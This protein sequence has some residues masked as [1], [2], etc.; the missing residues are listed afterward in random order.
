MG[1][2]SPK[3]QRSPEKSL[4]REVVVCRS[5]GRSPKNRCATVAEPGVKK[6]PF[7]SPI[8]KLHQHRTVARD[9]LPVMAL[10][11]PQI[12]RMLG[13]GLPNGSNKNEET[14][15]ES[16]NPTVTSCSLS[17]VG[18]SESKNSP[19]KVNEDLGSPPRCFDST[20]SMSIV[21]PSDPKEY[22]FN[23]LQTLLEST[24]IMLNA[25]PEDIVIQEHSSQD[26]LSQEIL[27]TA[28][29]MQPSPSVK[30]S[31]KKQCVA[32]PSQTEQ[33]PSPSSI[34]ELIQV[35]YHIMGP[36]T[37]PKLSF[38]Q[39]GMS[40]TEY[41]R[42]SRYPINLLRQKHCVSHFINYDTMSCYSIR[43]SYTNLPNSTIIALDSIKRLAIVNI[44]EKKY[45][46]YFNVSKLLLDVLN[47]GIFNE[48]QLSHPKDSWYK[49]AFIS[50]PADQQRRICTKLRLKIG[51]VVNHINNTGVIPQFCD[52]NISMDCMADVSGRC[53][54][55]GI[56]TDKHIDTLLNSLTA[57]SFTRTLS[58]NDFMQLRRSYYTNDTMV[59]IVLMHLSLMFNTFYGTRTFCASPFMFLDTHNSIAL[60]F[61]R[62]IDNG[63]R[64]LLGSHESLEE[65]R[66]LWL[67]DLIVFPV[68]C[69][70]HWYSYIYIGK[71]SK[72]SSLLMELC[73]GGSMETGRPTLVWM[74]KILQCNSMRNHPIDEHYNI[75]IIQ[76][77]NA[78]DRQLFSRSTARSIPSKSFTMKSVVPLQI[79]QQRD[80]YSCAYHMFV[81]V[82]SLL[83]MTMDGYKL[84]DSVTPDQL[85]TGDWSGLYNPASANAMKHWVLQYLINNSMYEEI[86]STTVN[87]A[88]VSKRESV[89]PELKSEDSSSSVHIVTDK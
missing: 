66:R 7:S 82:F 23:K 88:R 60:S 6:T 64:D 46:Q 26:R 69:N 15:H 63:T 35:K 37:L 77:M 48:E 54:K 41:D 58:R 61:Y 89:G 3:Q 43:R 28:Y 74:D 45:W 30:S 21:T 34:K 78:L 42:E 38:I 80:Q 39:R 29:V 19:Q 47:S 12:V 59:D 72:L 11:E 62:D 67:I 50:L 83:S 65:C 76:H 57:Q 33:S 9:L 86:Q 8:Q 4:Q 56:E 55:E 71:Q 27:Q 36:F 87:M 40:S 75:Q 22:H 85:A 18:P 52:D 2:P 16:T 1:T 84:P 25:S 20:Q 24:N 51:L 31:P 13:N 44:L 73:G 81:L 70:S 32:T 49:N 10:I 68:C 53:D 14:Q 79:C 5:P 17:R